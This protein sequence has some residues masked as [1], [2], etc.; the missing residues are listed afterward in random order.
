MSTDSKIK[1]I[2]CASI[3]CYAYSK[4]KSDLMDHMAEEYN[5]LST[6]C[7]RGLHLLIAWDTNDINLMPIL[8]LSPYLL[9]IVKKP[10]RADPVC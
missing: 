2:A 10:T 9:K 4:H 5:I 6:K 7:Q 8:N 1:K 3:Y